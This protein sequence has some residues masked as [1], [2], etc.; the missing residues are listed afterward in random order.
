V[1]ALNK[2]GCFGGSD[3]T[4]ILAK[5]PVT[6]I[7]LAGDWKC[8]DGGI[9]RIQQEIARREVEELKQDFDQYIAELEKEWQWFKGHRDEFKNLRD[10]RSAPRDSSSLAS[11]FDC[12][13]TGK[14]K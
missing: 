3:W 10:R 8:N 5:P 14:L 11:V 7:N 13:S 2:T 1:V 12:T 4:K 9:Y 6:F